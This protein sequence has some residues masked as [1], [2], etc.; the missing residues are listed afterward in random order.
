[1]VE[2]TSSSNTPAPATVF[3]AVV[4]RQYGSDPVQIELIDDELIVLVNGVQVD[5]SVLKVQRFP[6]V[7]ISFESN[8]TVSVS[9]T[10]GEFIR[11]INTNGFL[12][13]MIVSLPKSF[14]GK[15]RGL[16]GSYDGDM[17]TDLIP[18]GGSTPLSLDSTIQEIHESF[19]V[20]C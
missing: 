1:M 19:G 15:T 9:F 16:M 8:D 11:V 14:M 6:N 20:T 17:T 18:K 3:S 7:T 2:A 4:A 12:S 5:F 13:T 10:E